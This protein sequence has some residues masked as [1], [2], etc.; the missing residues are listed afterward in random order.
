MRVLAP[1][2]GKCEALECVRLDANAI[3]TQGV[4]ALAHRMC[5]NTCLMSLD[6]RDNSLVAADGHA[7]LASL[8]FLARLSTTRELGRGVG[9][10]LSEGASFSSVPLAHSEGKVGGGGGEGPFIKHIHVN[11]RSVCHGNRASGRVERGISAYERLGGVVVA[12]EVVLTGCGLG[13]ADMVALGCLASVTQG[14]NVRAINLSDS[15]L[16]A[17][18]CALVFAF[19]SPHAPLLFGTGYGDGGCGWCCGFGG[20]GDEGGGE[21]G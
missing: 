11:G 15:P 10:D 17:Q 20:G 13:V 14:Y 18:G 21:E 2:F 16:G 6:L 9:R 12:H 19:A 1:A 8:P 3:G 5:T 7:L 4:N